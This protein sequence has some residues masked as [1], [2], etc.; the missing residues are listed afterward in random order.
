MSQEETLGLINGL[1]AV[2]KEQNAS[3]KS[4][5]E[6]LKSLASA[7]ISRDLFARD[8]NYPTLM[9][10]IEAAKRYETKTTSIAVD[11]PISTANALPVTPVP[12]YP[13]KAPAHSQEATPKPSETLVDST[14][15]SESLYSTTVVIHST[16][17][18]AILPLNV[19]I[20]NIRPVLSTDTNVLEDAAD[21]T[22]SQVA[23][24]WYSL[25]SA[26]HAARRNIDDLPT[27]DP[28]KIVNGGHAIHTSN[29]QEM[30]QDNLAFDSSFLSPDFNYPTLMALIEAAKRYETKTTSIAVDE[31]I[32]TA[33]A[34]PVT[35][36][37]AY[38]RKAP[39][40]SQEATPK[41]SETLVDSTLSSESL[42]STTVVI[43]STKESAIL[44]LNVSIG[45]IRPVL[46]T[47]TN[48]LEDAADFTASQL[49]GAGIL[50]TGIWL[51][52]EKGDYV[53]FTDYEF[54]TASNLAIAAGVVIVVV[55]LLGVFFVSLLLIFCLEIAAGGLAYANRG[56]IE[57]EVRKDL[58]VT[59]H[60]KYSVESGATQAIDKMQE[61]FK[62]CGNNNVD[63]W[64]YSK[65]Y[66][67][68]GYVPES[69]CMKDKRNTVDCGKDLKN[70]NTRGCYKEV[71]QFLLDHL[72]IIGVTGI[73]F[74]VIQ[75]CG[76]GILG[77]GIWLR[78][79]KGDYASFSDYEFAT[80]SN[81][82]IGAGVVIVVVTFLG[83]VGSI[84]ENKIMLLM[85][86]I[87]L[88]LIFCLEISAGGLA[89][90]NKGKI[91]REV[92]KDL[93]LMISEKY[94]DEPGTTEAID[95]MQTYFKCCGNLNWNDWA[96][97]KFQ[98]GYPPKSCCVEEQ[99]NNNDC[100]KDPNNVYTKGC[101]KEISKFLLE[102]LLVIGVIGLAFSVIQVLGM[103]FSMWLFCG[104][105]KGTYA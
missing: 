70:V 95:K 36:V 50:G 26:T 57:T 71:K 33:N 24:Q 27:L 97:S 16:K 35:P 73:V 85:F 105:T 9:A 44:P 28:D 31:P 34:L 8:F 69:C 58:N 76:A 13:R 65:Y 72:L 39:A 89:Y 7:D 62:C 5:I 11:E 87:F 32:S 83:V 80:V 104:I 68:K 92:R 29:L 51:R 38:P 56:K 43:H 59:I 23:N 48:V 46:S 49:C 75:L 53:S 88:L 91:E 1:A 2:A 18:S 77:T 47:D 81:L 79:E 61:F 42:Y 74:G 15:S 17:E 86:F 20:G 19:S 40:H 102:H 4:R 45:N 66:V 94:G 60:E 10:L 82:A 67:S 78:V 14:L 64:K 22:A 3:N 37:P 12:A 101:Y 100:G 90:A 6:E 103:I 41:P 99:Q 52:V 25:V 55:T 84:K 63:D 98:K 96:N 54:A 30:A 21:F 93:S